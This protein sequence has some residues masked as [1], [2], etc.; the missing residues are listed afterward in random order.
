MLSL[1]DGW[2]AMRRSVTTELVRLVALV[3]LVV[4]GCVDGDVASDGDGLAV[5][6]EADNAGVGEVHIPG[7]CA[8][9]DE[10][11]DDDPCTVNT[12]GPQGCTVAEFAFE[13]ACDDGDPCTT[14]DQCTK[15]GECEGLAVDCEDGN[16]CTVDSCLAADGSCLSE[17]LP[18]GTVCEDGQ[19]CTESDSCLGGVCAGV[20]IACED[21]D[22]NDCHYLVCDT[23]SGACDQ[24]VLRAAGADCWDGDPCTSDDQCDG[25]GVCQAGAE[26]ECAANDPCKKAWCNQKTK[27][28]EN[29]CVEDWKEV[30]V[31]CDDGDSCTEEE[32]CLPVDGGPKMNCVGTPILCSDSKVCTAD[33]CDSQVGCVFEAELK[34][35][36][37]C[38]TV[39]GDCGTCQAGACTADPL[40]C[41]D[42]NA[43]T[44]DSCQTGGPCTYELLSDGLCNDNKPCTV[45]DHCVEGECVGYPMNCDDENE[46]T[47]D[48]CDNGECLHFHVED[49][50]PCDDGNACSVDDYCGNGACWPG[51]YSSSCV[52]L[53]GDGKCVYPDTP[54]LCPVDCGPCGDGICGTHEN[55]PNGGSC[56]L[57]CMAACGNG[58]C[59]GGESFLNCLLDCSGCGDGFCGMNESHALCAGDCPAACGDGQCE[60]G[61]SVDTCPPDC[62]P[63]CGDG[64]CNWGENTLNCPADCTYCGDAF[65][66]KEETIEACPKDCATAC[67]NGVCEGGESPEQC[68]VDCG[69]C[70][71]G[72]CGFVETSQVCPADC[73]AGCGNAMCDQDLNESVLTCPADCSQ[74]PDGD[75]YQGLEDNCPAVD[76]PDQLDFDA[77]GI[78]DACDF[79]DDNDQEGDAT[80][81]EPFDPAV[82]HLQPESCDGKDNDCDEKID[83]DEPLGCVAYY[84]DADEDG[85]GIDSMSKCL[86][87]PWESFSALLAGD[88]EPLEPTIYPEAEEVCNGL[89]EDCDGQVDEDF[90]D[91]DGDGVADCLDD[92][93]DDDAVPDNEDN[94]PL[95]PNPTQ[96]NWDSDV[97]GDACD[98]DDD[99]DGDP[100][101]DDC[102]PFEPAIS[103]L[104]DELC[105]GIDDNCNDQ[106][107]IDDPVD[108]L[109]WYL[110]QD[111]DG[112]GV[113]GKSLCMC[114]PW[115]LYS[116]L[117]PGDCQPA[118]KT[119]HPD[120]L[121]LC[122]GVDDN[123]NDEIDE[124]A[125]C[126]D[127]VECTVDSCQGVD[128]CLHVPD[129]EVCDDAQ[130]CTTDMCST[131][132]GCLQLPVDDDIPCGEWPNGRCEAGVC[133]CAPTCGGVECGED[134]CGG[135]C[136]LCDE[137][138][139]CLFGA[140]TT[141]E[142]AGL[143]EFAG[144]VF[145]AKDGGDVGNESG[146]M[147][148]PFQ[149]IIAGV[150][151]AAAQE[152]IGK[153][154]VGKGLYN[155][156][157]ELP[158]GM[159]ICGGYL[160][161][162]GWVREPADHLTTIEWGQDVEW[163]VVALT[164]Q[165]SDMPALVDGFTVRSG[166]AVEPGHSSIAVHVL[167]GGDQLR[168]NDVVL[169]AGAGAKGED[170]VVGLPGESGEEGEAGEK[171][172]GMGLLGNEH[173][174]GGPGATGPELPL[175]FPPEYNDG[176]TGGEGGHFQD[177][178]T[179]ESGT[180]PLGG[181]G[182]DGGTDAAEPLPGAE[183]AVG[184]HG[185][186]G[187]GGK[188]FEFSGGQITV[189][190]GKPGSQGDPGGGGGGG[191]GG[192]GSVPLVAKYTGGGGGGGGSGGA[193]GA[194]GSGGK[195]GGASIGLLGMMP[196]A[197]TN[198]VFHYGP[199]GAGGVGGDGGEGGEGG[200]GGA[201]GPSEYTMPDVGADGGN[202]GKGGDGGSGGGGAGG[203]AI[204]YLAV[205]G[206]SAATTDSQFVQE[207][208]G[209]A[210]GAG[211]GGN[212]PGEAGN[213]GATKEVH[214]KP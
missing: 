117:V 45:D 110:D 77:D 52:M 192:E 107:D 59:E 186:G 113:E 67:G 182:G 73:A 169:V 145:V 185:T 100:D 129:A 97:P 25:E 68:A 78:G 106:I 31:A 70:G 176:G 210:G 37:L 26:Y 158:A 30:G 55:G 203:P 123:C 38:N 17:P 173:S 83:E 201:G 132:E 133:V 49:N 175:E 16:V 2:A 195:G 181:A 159:I 122:N 152:P 71:D 35:G 149:T 154:Y 148:Q 84:L 143:D 183:G 11:D 47:D 146:S 5:D 21:P 18:D 101:V 177:G 6:L 88:C 103:N 13:A 79:D 1:V 134:G 92:D 41:D 191:G 66:G 194:G 142:C 62:M 28:G 160:R 150:A 184:S 212:A 9:D 82:S 40:T 65:C 44:A 138:N 115:E 157:V 76:N 53:C 125:L 208:T 124:Q 19:L 137:G 163:A 202:G 89:D 87:E 120:A 14:D 85:Y 140:C 69:N 15:D 51:A 128:G 108:C 60:Q 57:D 96:E 164:I 198:C 119:A 102:E 147:E 126:D 165:T 121:E 151:F 43:C 172:H 95:V 136:G 72:V 50:L 214:T 105:N 3:C 131:E 170:G 190:W 56:P 153:V 204:G 116:T 99:N 174:D 80:D 93:D 180:P 135:L 42:G 4:A 205:G 189:F 12:C 200:A 58:N 206:Q 111:Q 199:G 34:E 114:E 193:C 7:S 109:T 179:G 213:P 211:G 155:E 90:P 20:P 74:D 156:Q 48:H 39:A 24:I 61:E 166:D 168:L 130:E 167:A 127:A 161:T 197:V 86:C 187:N 118:E 32:T 162:A 196:L 75:G 33:L 29:P 8:T 22:E 94:C 112:F 207:G 81:C 46:C 188:G 54:Q 98:D 104:A 171:A 139:A 141:T 144:V 91:T 27:E 23:L 178:E 209:G 10:C 63:P 36:T 64:V